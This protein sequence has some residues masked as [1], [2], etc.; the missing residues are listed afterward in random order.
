M[1]FFLFF[2]ELIEISNTILHN[3]IITIII[4]ITVFVQHRSQ[5]IHC[6]QLSNSRL[7]SLYPNHPLRLLCCLM[8]YS[9]MVNVNISDVTLDHLKPPDSLTKASGDSTD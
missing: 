2:I 4:I 5:T 9:V 6:H 8:M 1:I 7:T 3:I